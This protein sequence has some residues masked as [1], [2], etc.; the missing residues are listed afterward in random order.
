MVHLLREVDIVTPD[1]FPK[2]KTLLVLIFQ[3]SWLIK[4][5]GMNDKVYLK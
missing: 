3:K 4:Y 1:T 5:E 2:Y